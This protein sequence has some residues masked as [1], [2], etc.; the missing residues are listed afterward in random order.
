MRATRSTAPAPP[1]YACGTIRRATASSTVR[2][3]DESM[4]QTTTGDAASYPGNAGLHALARAVEVRVV[5]DHSVAGSGMIPYDS[6]PNS[7][8]SS[9]SQQPA[10]A[11]SYQPPFNAD[12]SWFL[13]RPFLRRTRFCALSHDG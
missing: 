3:C 11:A 5:R 8:P 7:P 1:S 9:V 10:L 13:A 12:Q 6:D 4:A 2:C